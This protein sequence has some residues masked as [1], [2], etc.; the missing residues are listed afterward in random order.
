MQQAASK[1]KEKLF[2]LYIKM[3]F[4]GH[5]YNISL[6]YQSSRPLF[7]TLHFRDWNVSLQVVSTQLG[8]T[9]WRL[10]STEYVPPEDG[11]E[12]QSLKRCFKSETR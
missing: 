9:S 7:K 12:I 6:H 4:Y 11:A 10:S 1:Q 8:P 3:Q 5:Y 2:I